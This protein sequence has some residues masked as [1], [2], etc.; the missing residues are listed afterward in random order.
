MTTTYSPMTELEAVNQ[1]LATIGETPINSLTASGSV[2]V[3]LA[4]QLLHTTSRAVQAQG[5][6]FNTEKEYTL[7]LDVDSKIAV[8]GNVLELDTSTV[9]STYDVTRRGGFLYDRED[10]TFIFDRALKLD[11]T[12]FLP[13]EDIP[14]SARNYITVRAARIFQD[15]QVGAQILH[16]FSQ[17]DEEDALAIFKASEGEEGDYNILWD[18]YSVASVLE[19]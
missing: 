19:R 9:D 17:K 13:F 16:A 5:W 10:H 14:Q 8:P 15:Q 1:I 3:A 4:V 18:N 7:P 11:I 6:H 12:W 2:D